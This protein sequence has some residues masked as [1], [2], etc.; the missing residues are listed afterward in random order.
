MQTPKRD[1][2][3]VQKILEEKVDLRIQIRDL[4]AQLAKLNKDLL[5]AGGNISELAA[6]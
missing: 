4:R 3:Q 1:E 5:K 2:V 6:W